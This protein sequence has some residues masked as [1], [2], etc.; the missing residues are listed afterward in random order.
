M[1]PFTVQ[2]P[3]TVSLYSSKDELL[4]GQNIS[5]SSAIPCQQVTVNFS[6]FVKILLAVWAGSV[7]LKDLKR[8]ESCLDPWKS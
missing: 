6:P 5:Y 8:I 7:K 4:K 1:H 2:F 3:V